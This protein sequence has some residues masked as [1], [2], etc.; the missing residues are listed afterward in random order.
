VREGYTD[1]NNFNADQ[2][3]IFFTL[4]PDKT[5]KFKEKQWNGM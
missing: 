4:T 3:G 2:T 5:L 1:S